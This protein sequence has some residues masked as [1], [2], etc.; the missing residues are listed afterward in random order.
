MTAVEYRDRQQIQ[1]AQLQAEEA[2]QI[3]MNACRAGEIRALVAR[4]WAMPMGPETLR[5]R[6]GTSVVTMRFRTTNN[7]M[8]NVDVPFVAIRRAAWADGQVER[9]DR[10]QTRSRRN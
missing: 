10:C 9:V 7:N 3:Q 1:D 5:Q 8:D 6:N 2:Q 4:T